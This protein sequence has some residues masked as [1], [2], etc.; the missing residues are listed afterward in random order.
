MTALIWRPWLRLLGPSAR[1]ERRRGPP[2][3]ARRAR[4]AGV[5]R[6]E[7][8]RA[9][10]ALGPAAV[11][12]QR[13]RRRGPPAARDVRGDRDR[14]A[15]RR[16]H[17]AAGLAG[18]AHRPGAHRPR[19][20]TDRRGGQRGRA[21]GP[22]RGR[23]RRGALRRRAGR[24]LP[25]ARRYAR[26]SAAGSRTCRRRRRTSSRPGWPRS[27]RPSGTS[28]SAAPTCSTPSCTATIPPPA[29]R[30][31]TSSGST[32]SSAADGSGSDDD[33][34][35]RS[36]GRRRRHADARTPSTAADSRRRRQRSRHCRRASGAATGSGSSSA[37]RCA[38]ALG[39]SAWANSSDPRFSAPLDPQ[40]PD[41]DGA[42]AVAQVLEDEGVEVSI[43]RSADELHDADVAT[44]TTV[45]VTGT[46]ELAPSTTRRLR[47]DTAGADV[48]LV[49]PPAY[50]VEELQASVEPAHASDE[51][52]GDCDDSRFD[53][54]DLT[55]DQ[56]SSYDT[57]TGCFPSNDGFVL[58][59]GAGT[60]TYFGAGQALSND[61]VLR[62]DNAAVA[63]RLLGEHDRLVWY[64][65]THDDADDDEAVSLWTFAPDW[66]APSLWL[67]GFAAIGLILWRGR[68]LGKLATEPLPVVVR[69]VET[70][71]SRGRMYR[72]RRRPRLRRRG[73]ARRR[74]APPRRPPPARSRRVGGRGGHG[75]RPAHRPPR[76]GGRHPPLLPGL[77]PDHGPGTGPARPRSH[78][79][80]QRG[81]PRMTLEPRHRWH[82]RRCGQRRT[83]RAA[84]CRPARG[85]QGG[86]R[87]GR[88][89][90]RPAR[91]PPLRR[92]R[93]D[94]GRARYGEDPSR[95]HP[96][97]VVGRRHPPGAV[98]ARPDAGRH[99]RLARHRQHR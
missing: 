64:V 60:T 95:A 42:Q 23:P 50:V 15:A 72:T 19:A 77:R 78:P 24:R 61:Q 47:G 56:A 76:G 48:V 97:R 41:P 92:P 44:G 63:L 9:D 89:R 28:S 10:P 99:H 30:R 85:G 68:R 57:R 66:I 34:A 79:A 29:S 54:L 31:S 22:R 70:T 69:A 59:T 5:Q 73:A 25:R 75:R 12:R 55:V 21:A 14:A 18:P 16:R 39:V 82:H 43:V 3:A 33:D 2:A 67:V 6:H 98:H 49:E 37:S 52:S 80:R 90:L 86:R 91:R 53:E 4:E 74:P 27:S 8:D 36:P 51:T 58:A 81:T 62:G 65:P 1:P 96:G 83:A 32:T 45:V 20:G 38:L 71:R 7:P 35:H 17:R 26:S 88:R 93:A 11:R 94:G 40:N 46:E 84:P 13:R 87:P